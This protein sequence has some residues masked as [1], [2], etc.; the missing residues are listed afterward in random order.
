[1]RKRNFLAVSIALA[2]VVIMGSCSVNDD[3]HENENNAVR[4]SAGVG[5]MAS[6]KGGTKAAGN[7][8]APNDAIGIFMA[9]NG[10][11]TNILAANKQYTT[12]GDGNFTARAGDEIFY[13]MDGSKVDFIA[14]YPW[15]NNKLM[16]DVLDVDVAGV[17]TSATQ[18][19]TDLLWAK[20]DNSGSGYDKVTNK[21]TAVALAFNHKL[22]K[23]V[24]KCNAAPN[25]GISNFDG[26]TV[27]ING[28]NTKNT[29][30][31]SD[32]TLGTPDIPAAITPRKLA[33]SEA[34][35]AAT[36][37]AI[38]LPETYAV[39]V[40][41]VE[42]TIPGGDVFTWKVPATTFDGG[43]EYVYEVILSR[44]GVEFTGTIKQWNTID[45]GQMTAE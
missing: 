22:A 14:Y 6:P 2:V 35:F 13:P 18:A 5:E 19:A 31:L 10:S 7:Q 44:T 12:T 36:Y 24:M 37:D 27:S 28:M 20:A 1:M 16:S 34:G 11:T 4:F 30:T 23:M 25:V 15:A 9:E 41:T 8:W 42:F 17:Q 40:V 43:S 38:I 29:F 3:I 45:R 39:N 26:V 33:A 21:N 32:G